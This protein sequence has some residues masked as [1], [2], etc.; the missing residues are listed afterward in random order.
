MGV[1]FEKCDN[2]K[3][4]L[5]TQCFPNCFCCYDSI[6]D[7]CCDCVPDRN[8]VDEKH[9]DYM[10]DEC[11][12]NSTDDEIKESG[13][14]YG[15]KILNV[16]KIIRQVKKLRQ[17]YFNKAERLKRLQSKKERYLKDIEDLNNEI[18]AINVEI[19]LIE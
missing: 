14:N 4:C 10:C 17:T 8:C 13:T 6:D 11:I 19:G 18:D 2:C 3:E 9:E 7:L 1:D 5:N 12:Q 16:T 15:V